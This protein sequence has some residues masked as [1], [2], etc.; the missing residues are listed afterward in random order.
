MGD[1]VTVAAIP[2][3]RAYRDPFGACLADERQ[4]LDNAGFA[5]TVRAVSG[6]FAAAGLGAGDVVAIALPNRVEFVTS[7]FAAWRLGAAVTP[8]DPASTG[9]R[10]QIAD[11]SATLIVLDDMAAAKLCGIA[12]PVVSLDAVSAPARPGPPAPASSISDMPALL[13]YPG[14]ETGRPTGVVLDHANVGAA[15][16]RICGWYAMDSATRSLLVRPLVEVDTIMVSVVAPLLS[17][18][19][20]VIV[21]ALDEDGARVVIERAT[22]TYLSADPGTYRRLVTGPVY[23]SMAT[24]LRYAISCGSAMPDELILEFERLY[25]V[26]MVEAYGTAECTAYCTANPVYGLRKPGTVGLPLPDVDVGVVDARGGL[27][28]SGV[29]GEVV[30]RGP[31][32]MRGYLGRPRESAHRLRGGW[33]HSGETGMFD[34][35]GYLMLPDR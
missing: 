30:V 25:C 6:V 5:A 23:R 19:S 7:L 1:A 29:A 24:D 33:F 31:N 27:L 20:A 3:I 34:Q 15:A 16:Q 10:E 35:D 8:V 28:P 18:G 14:D 11:A 12:L 4:E 17:A 26:P 32:V 22:P 21:D 2:D 13:I 9:A